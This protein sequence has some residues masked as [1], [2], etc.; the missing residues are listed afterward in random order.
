MM[1]MKKLAMA[2]TL[3]A[4]VFASTVAHAH[5]IWFAQRSTQLALMYG[6][7]ADDLDMVKRFPNITSTTAYGPDGKAVPTSL[8]VDGRLVL[9]STEHQPSV[10]ASVLE[11]GMWCKTPDGKW[12]KKGKDEVPDAVLSQRTIKYTVHIRGP[13]T[14]PIGPLPGHTLQIVPVSATLPAMMGEPIKLRVL[15]NGKP[16]AGARVMHDFL[17]DPDGKPVLSGADGTIT[18]KVRN[19]GLNVIMAVIDAPTDQPTKYNHLEHSASLS[20]VLPHLPE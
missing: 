3:G 20:F 5:G 9:V 14:A 17:N 13:L 1:K 19:Q 15:L 11:N 4:T 6:V 12:H 2:I 18:L 7:G 10:V 16:V 8:Y